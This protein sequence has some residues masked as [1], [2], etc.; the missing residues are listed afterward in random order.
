[1]TSGDISCPCYWYIAG[2][3]GFAK[4]SMNFEIKL[5]PGWQTIYFCQA[6]ERK[7][8]KAKL[9]TLDGGCEQLRKK[10]FF[11]DISKQMMSTGWR[12][13]VEY[14]CQLAF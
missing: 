1:M 6:T 5:T 4:E 12:V 14:N 2:D 8:M 13:G 10:R 9:S 7:A 11:T 3:V